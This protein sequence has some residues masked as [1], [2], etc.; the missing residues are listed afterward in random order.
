ME[1]MLKTY[2][3]ILDLLSGNKEHYTK[4]TKLSDLVGDNFDYIDFLLSVV[5][6][7]TTYKIAMPKDISD[8]LD[9][10]VEQFIKKMNKLPEEK[11][12]M[13]VTKQI[14]KLTGYLEDIMTA[15]KELETQEDD[16]DTN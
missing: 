16:D 4:E 12:E 3:A 14:I 15:Q 11:D 7:E 6:L 9:I 10:T 5:S 8:D 2:L 1:G 13:F